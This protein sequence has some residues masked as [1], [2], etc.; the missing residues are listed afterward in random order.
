MKRVIMLF[1]CMPMLVWAKGP[2]WE[3]EYDIYH[4]IDPYQKL[5]AEQYQQEERWYY[6][7]IFVSDVSIATGSLSIT[8]PHR[9]QEHLD[10]LATI[11]PVEEYGIDG[12]LHQMVF[13]MAK[14]Y[15]GAWVEG[16]D[17]TAI[18]Q[19]AWRRCMNIPVARFN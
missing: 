11:Y 6:C 8:E 5:T 10:I 3:V 15:A 16:A 7:S 14:Q 13:D 2:P 19:E 4:H 9:V 18:K 1:L 12:E 17:N